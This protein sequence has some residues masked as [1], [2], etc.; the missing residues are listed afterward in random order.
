MKLLYIM[1]A[2]VIFLFIFS[3]MYYGLHFI[4]V[5]SAMRE[6]YNVEGLISMLSMAFSSIMTIMAECV[7]VGGLE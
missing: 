3:I 1:L 7:L 2:P 4:L 6:A 5:M